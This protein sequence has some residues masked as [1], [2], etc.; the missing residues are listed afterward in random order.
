MDNLSIFIDLS[1]RIKDI[2]MK[3]DAVI[4]RLEICE[5]QLGRRSLDLNLSAS[6]NP[7]DQYVSGL[8]TESCA[9]S[10][11]HKQHLEDNL[12]SS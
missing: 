3:L 10:P 8:T 4:L 2:E 9:P 12:L 7:L 11:V 1:E 6:I 5:R